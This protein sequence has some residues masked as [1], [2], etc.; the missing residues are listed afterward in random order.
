MEQSPSYTVNKQ[1]MNKHCEQYATF[2]ER[3]VCVC[4]WQIYITL[5]VLI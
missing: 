2:E 3:G 4:V 5:L 1:G